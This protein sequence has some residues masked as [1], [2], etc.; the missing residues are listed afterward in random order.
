ME[1][2][3]FGKNGFYAMPEIPGFQHSRMHKCRGRQVAA[4]DCK[5][6][7]DY[8]KTYVYGQIIREIETQTP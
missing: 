2:A 6:H 7:P 1:L 8:R 5:L 3:E 4:S